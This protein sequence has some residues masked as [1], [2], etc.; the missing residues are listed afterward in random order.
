MLLAQSNVA[1]ECNLLEVLQR[2]K[3]VTSKRA[4]STDFFTEVVD[5]GVLRSA[6]Q[7]DD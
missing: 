5:H 1:S 4:I 7:C 6:V 2:K 3:V